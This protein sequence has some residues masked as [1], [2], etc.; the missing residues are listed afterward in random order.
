MLLWLSHVKHEID[1][2]RQQ[3]FKADHRRSVFFCL[4]IIL[5]G[6]NMQEIVNFS[7]YVSGYLNRIIISLRKLSNAEHFRKTNPNDQSY[8]K[9]SIL[10]SRRCN[11]TLLLW[12]IITEDQE[13]NHLKFVNLFH[14]SKQI[15][16]IIP[17]TI[18]NDLQFK[19]V[20]VERI[21]LFFSSS[22]CSDWVECIQG[23]ISLQTFK[24]NSEIRWFKFWVD[25]VLGC[26]GCSHCCCCLWCA[27]VTNDIL[28]DN[29]ASL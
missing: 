6:P 1:I 2:G 24:L 26:L 4:Q 25:G 12:I 13:K 23:T 21:T 8:K 7:P 28:V 3:R 14:V 18:T 11:K 29:D 19:I 16:K 10:C 15:R 22:L 20:D 27:T 17:Q 5:H 9:M